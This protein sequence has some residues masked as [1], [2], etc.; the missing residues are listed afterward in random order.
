[1][2]GIID[3]I[4]EKHVLMLDAQASYFFML[5][6]FF[7]AVLEDSGDESAAEVFGGT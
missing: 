6:A 5:V 7:M 4:V 1:M 2:A 3:K